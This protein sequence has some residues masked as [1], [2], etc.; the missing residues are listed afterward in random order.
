MIE[1][2]EKLRELERRIDALV[3]M[4]IVASVNGDAVT[5]SY[6]DLPDSEPMPYLLSSSGMDVTPTV[7]DQAMVIMPGGD[8]LLAQALCG[9]SST[10]QAKGSKTPPSRADKV[11][12][13]LGKIQAAFDAHT[14]SSFG[15]PPTTQA[16]T[17][18]IGTDPF[19]DP[20]TDATKVKV[21]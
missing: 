13:A 10:D 3:R 1:V 5:V 4:G 15:T 12:T 19:W 2:W 8:P 16:P 11:S 6:P 21:D 9:V 18:P 20:D 17:I 7:G 14:H